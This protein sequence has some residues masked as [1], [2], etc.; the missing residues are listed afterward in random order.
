MI[1]VLVGREPRTVGRELEQH[2][3]RFLE[4]HRLEPEPIDDIGGVPAAGFDLRSHRQLMPLVVDAPR[5]V[6]DGAHAPG[7]APLARHLAHVHDAR[8]IVE[9][10]P[11]PSALAGQ[12][13]KAEHGRQEQRRD[14]AVLLPELRAV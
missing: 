12:F 11:R 1:G 8:H 9:A 13:A 10:I 4:I 2:P 5:E 3:S 7:A 6:M 14:R